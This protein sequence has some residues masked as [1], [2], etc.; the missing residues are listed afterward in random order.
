MTKSVLFRGEP[1]TWTALCGE[2]YPSD[3]QLAAAVP[4]QFDVATGWA[5]ALAV[6][7]VAWLQGWMTPNR[8]A[9]VEVID[10]DRAA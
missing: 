10:D 5:A 8:F 2:W 1:L 9:L 3:V 6:R 4:V 7:L